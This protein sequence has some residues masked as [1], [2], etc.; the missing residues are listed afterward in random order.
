MLQAIESLYR[1]LKYRGYITPIPHGEV[2][3][4]LHEIHSTFHAHFKYNN[5]H[6]HCIMQVMLFCA[7]SA[8]LL[9]AYRSYLFI[10]SSTALLQ[11]PLYL[12][13]GVVVHVVF[14]IVMYV[15]LS[16]IIDPEKDYMMLLEVSS[17]KYNVF[18]LLTKSGYMCINILR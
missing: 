4:S 9:P 8:V 17:R 1:M 12:Q 7:A 13:T 14:F 16:C 6:V 18:L 10:H 2:L 5:I 11:F 15:V 3:E